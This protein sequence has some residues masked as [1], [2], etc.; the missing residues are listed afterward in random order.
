MRSSRLHVRRRFDARRT[1]SMYSRLSLATRTPAE[2]EPRQW[3]CHVDR[4]NS[5][6]GQCIAA[7]VLYLFR[8]ETLGGTGFYRPLRPPMEIG[9]LAQDS[10]AMARDEF[11]DRYGLQAGY[12]TGSNAYFEKILSVPPRWNR[13]IFYSGMVFHCGDITSAGKAQPRPAP[14]SP[15]PQWL[16]Y[17]PPESFVTSS[18]RFAPTALLLIATLVAGCAHSP[19]P[20]ATT[21]QAV[22]PTVDLL[23]VAAPG[24]APA[25]L[26]VRVYLPPGYDAK[27]AIGY[28]V[29][30]VNDG[31][32]MEAV[33]LEP[34]LAALYAQKEIR[35]VIVVAIDMPPDRMGGYGLSD[36]QQARSVAADTKY[37]PVGA[38]AHAYSEWVTQDAGAD[39]RRA[40]PH[41]HHAGRAC[42]PGLVAGRTQRLQPRL[43]VS[44]TCSV[45]SAPSRHRSG[46]PRIAMMPTRCNGRGWRSAWS[47]APRRATVPAS[48]SPSAPRRKP[49]IATKTA[50][51][52]R[53]TTP[54][55]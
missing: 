38:Q 25:P 12:M 22:P 53:S 27:A 7:S 51:T 19:P 34:T 55:T 8:D 31:Q 17:L 35:P 30:Y 41:A 14:G 15:H 5:T 18:A 9:R 10:A 40:L 4:M 26:R 6:P 20:P 44:G 21:T 23:Q 1:L 43:A 16:L 13:L 11:S 28:P 50:S 3:L 48:I 37:G 24:V 36:R 39:D 49:T 2:L 29:L 47:L 42:G 46:C 33:G 45:A 54:A 52:M 32:D